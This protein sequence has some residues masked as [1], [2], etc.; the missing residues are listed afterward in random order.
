M[1]RVVRYIQCCQRY[2]SAISLEQ[3][4]GVATLVAICIFTLLLSTAHLN[5]LSGDD[6]VYVHRNESLSI[7]ESTIMNYNG[8]TGRISNSVLLGLIYHLV[9][10]LALPFVSTVLSLCVFAVSFYFILRRT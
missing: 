8:W 10:K 2:C 9:P 1:S 7:I 5:V 3:W 6:L 4:L